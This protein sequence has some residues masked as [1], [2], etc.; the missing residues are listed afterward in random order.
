M[1]L[2]LTCLFSEFS[3]H[4][5]CL[6]QSLFLDFFFF[7]DFYR[8]TYTDLPKPLFVN[9]SRQEKNYLLN[10]E[11]QQRGSE[12]WSW[13]IKT[14]SPPYMRE[15]RRQLSKFFISIL[16]EVWEDL[17]SSA[18]QKLTILI[19]LT[20]KVKS[21]LDN[22]ASGFALIFCSSPAHHLPPVTQAPCCFWTGLPM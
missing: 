7:L 2:V 17:I 16:S 15:N 1:G 6:R 21:L 19:T 5:L 8:H 9:I 22:K 20:I 10:V 4:S 14:N 13:A 18:K 11:N 3:T 12:Q